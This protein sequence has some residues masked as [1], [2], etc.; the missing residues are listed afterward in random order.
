M[1]ILRVTGIALLSLFIIAFASFCSD[2]ETR[3]A[4]TDQPVLARV[5]KR[6][7]TPV[8]FWI[9]RQLLYFPSE[10]AHYSTPEGKKALLKH[11]VGMELFY[12]EGVRQGLEKDPKIKEAVENFKR[13]LIYHTMIT[14]N[15]TPE[16][17]ED[18]FQRNFYHVAVIKLSNPEDASEADLNEIEAQAEKILEKLK[19]G[20]DFAELAEK[21][22]DLPS[23][24][25]GGD[26][27]IIG[28][29][30]EWPS[31][32][33]QAAASLQE[34]GDISR[35]VK[36]EDG[37]YILKLLEPHGQME[38]SGLTNRIQ[39]LIYNTMIR[40]NYKNFVTQL[41]AI[42]DIEFNPENLEYVE[43][44]KMGKQEKKEIAVPTIPPP[45]VPEVKEA[46]EASEK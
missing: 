3:Q 8:D 15:I 20:A 25:N 19:G 34:V 21:Y 33:L 32:V 14:R 9:T 13:Y 12:Q 24:D 30:G 43:P 10:R 22:S 46:A 36:A 41:Q 44:G 7:I 27:G 26:P 1:R 11:M 31:G 45:G 4:K 18:Y 5:N 17:M 23:A 6:A 39:E 28:Y 40:E 16:S 38:L 35:V 29:T 37:F 2:E 42:A